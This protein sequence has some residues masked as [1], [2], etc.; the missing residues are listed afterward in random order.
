MK[1][2]NIKNWLTSKGD[3][4]KDATVKELEQVDPLGAK[5]NVTSKVT[6]AANKAAKAK[7]KGTTN[8][9]PE[10]T[11]KIPSRKP[12]ISFDDQ[13]KEKTWKHKLVLSWTIVVKYK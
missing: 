8:P 13:Q 2:S 11:T 5:Q 9:D 10:T 12:T 4:S 1:G 7:H 3:K 6:A